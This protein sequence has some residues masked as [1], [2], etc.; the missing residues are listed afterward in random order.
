M[1]VFRPLGLLALLALLHLYP[2]SVAPATQS[3]N[4]HADAKLLEW[5]L[6]WIGRALVVQPLHLLDGNIF[7]PEPKVL[8]LSD[9]LIGPGL[10][11][12]PLVWL[13]ASPVL[14]YN[15][16]QL[17]GFVLTAWAGWFVAW[18]WTGS[19]HA[20]LV[21]GALAAF[22][23]H[24]LAR[25]A[26][27][28]AAHFWPVPLAIYV[29]DRLIDRPTPRDVLR[30]AA[31]VAVT[32]VTSLYTMTFAA[33]AVAIVA[34]GGL[35]RWRGV[36][37]IGTAGALGIA[38][39]LPVLW[40][41]VE[42]GRSGASRPLE[43]VARFAAPLEAYATG[44]SVLFTWMTGATDRD[45]TRVLF[46]GL[47]ALTLA[48]VGIAT[49]GRWRG[50]AAGPGQAARRRV[51]TLAAIGAIG[52]GLSLGPSTPVYRW[53]YEI[54]MP[55][56]GLR[57]VARFGSLYLMAVALLAAF[58]LAWIDAR[59]RGRT[60]RAMLIAIALAMVTAESWMGPVRTEP[61]T[62]L[63]PIYAVLRDHPGP[64]L[65]VETPFWPADAMFENSEYVL[66]AAAHWR[67][68][69]N[70]YSGATPQSYR[71][72]ADAFWYFPRDWAID[73]MIKE[74]ATHIMV[75]FDRFD[76]RDSDD[77]EASLPKR[78][79]LRLVASDELGHRLYEVKR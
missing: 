8:T 18:R 50:A 58:G 69:M 62:G 24:S 9:P 37:A 2:I 21:A 15:V 17:V 64:V 1:R 40:P 4:Y 61:F 6:S 16:V 49:A 19:A 12:A 5:T 65:L 26:H 28:Q 33:A 27:V 31:L 52:V 48:V 68:V 42:L 55:L 74:G 22:N 76:R 11:G 71:T 7:A 56:R 25:L 54:V 66:N 38:V 45:E 32:A 57:T 35:R 20:A 70:G 72:R 43:V 78:P 51:L 60:A 75:H 23:V 29:A 34:L 67:P 14:T 59:V 30:L 53:L 36:A 47:A 63:P 73:A 46:A 41:Y 10:I 79:D 44:N 3:I 13:G 77:I 39:T